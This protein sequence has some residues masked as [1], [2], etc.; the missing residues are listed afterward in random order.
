MSNRV[1]ERTKW[2][3]VSAV[4]ADCVL[5]VD[6]AQATV[7]HWRLALGVVRE[8]R[9]YAYDMNGAGGRGAVRG[10]QGAAAVTRPAL[11]D[12]VHFVVRGR[13]QHS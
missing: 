3:K 10:A 8:G 2:L 13:T 1:G 11:C 5:A 9:V 12:C 7:Q 4:R 6:V